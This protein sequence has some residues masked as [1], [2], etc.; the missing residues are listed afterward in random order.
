MTLK[1]RANISN[2]HFFAFRSRQFTMASLMAWRRLA[3]AP[4]V[5]YLVAL[6][7]HVTELLSIAFRAQKMLTRGSPVLACV[8]SADPGIFHNTT[9]R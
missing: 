8:Q 4:A 5:S 3:A 6:G 9:G 1:K 7:S 2:A